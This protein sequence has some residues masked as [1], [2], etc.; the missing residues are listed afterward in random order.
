[1]RTRNPNSMIEGKPSHILLL[2]DHDPDA[3][4][5]QKLL[6]ERPPSPRVLRASRLEDA[7]TVARNEVVELA[8]LDLNVIDSRGLSTSS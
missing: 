6:E 1:M 4:L 8:L 2:E 7:L 3:F 5:L